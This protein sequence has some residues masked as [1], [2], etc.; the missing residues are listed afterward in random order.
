MHAVCIV[1]FSELITSR[2]TFITMH[3]YVLITHKLLICPGPAESHPTLFIFMAR[4][5]SSRALQRSYGDRCLPISV[6][7][8]FLDHKG[9]RT[10][11]S[12]LIIAL[13]RPGIA[14]DTGSS[15]HS[16]SVLS[17]DFFGEVNLCMT[18]RYDSD[19]I[20]S[21]GDDKRIPQPF[22]L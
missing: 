6:T 12:L 1:L 19:Q 17:T 8:D 13:F 20:Q 5:H 2:I 21:T 7:F 16:E 4:L 14:R 22:H 18:F 10:S 15:L 3:N 9:R 11:P